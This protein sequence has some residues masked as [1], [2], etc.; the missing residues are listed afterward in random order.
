MQCGTET[1]GAGG[2]LPERLQRPAR[3][4]APSGRSEDA[5]KIGHGG[6]DVFRAEKDPCRGDIAECQDAAEN[7][8]Q[9]NFALQGALQRSK[10]RVKKTPDEETGADAVPEAAD[11]EHRKGVPYFFAETAP[12]AAEGNV[13]IVPEPGR[14]GDVPAAPEF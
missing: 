8:G 14:E 7:Q 1:C 5:G 11:E 13:D 12:A 9:M 2:V 6:A 3:L 4:C 10:G